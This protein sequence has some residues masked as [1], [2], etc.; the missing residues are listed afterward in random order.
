MSQSATDITLQDIFNAAW[1]HFVEQDNPPAVN[2]LGDNNYTCTYLTGDG[3]K[4]AVGLCIPD[5]HVAQQCICGFSDLIDINKDLFPTEHAKL[6]AGDTTGAW[7]S[8]H[9]KY[10]N[11]QGMLHDS[12]VDLYTGKWKSKYSTPDKRRANYIEAASR[13]H[14]T[15][16]S[17]T[18]DDNAHSQ[19]PTSSS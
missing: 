9:G 5:G 2:R 14:L 13:F 16:P 12:M 4:C 8:E 10:S 19:H 17:N 18:K 3:R 1:K 7:P 11:F 6:H 15:I